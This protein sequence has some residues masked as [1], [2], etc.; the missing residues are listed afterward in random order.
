MLQVSLCFC[1]AESSLAHRSPGRGTVISEAV[2][3]HALDT[4]KASDPLR[5]MF[6][7]HRSRETLQTY[8]SPSPIFC[9]IITTTE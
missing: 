2:A 3:D 6:A 7:A 8:N 9:N 5:T 4:S 1:C